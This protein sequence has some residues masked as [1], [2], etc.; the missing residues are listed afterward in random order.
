MGFQDE[1]FANGGSDGLIDEVVAWGDEAA[2]MK[3]IESHWEAGADHVCL[4]AINPHR[5]LG[6]KGFLRMDQGLLGRL[7]S[8]V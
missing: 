8:H 1:D 7:S 2:I 5:A 4:Q 3:R 6:D